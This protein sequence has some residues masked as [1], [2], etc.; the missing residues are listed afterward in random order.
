MDKIGR[1]F[2]LPYVDWRH[3]ILLDDSFVREMHAVMSEPRSDA[4]FYGHVA[5]YLQLSNISSEF[6]EKY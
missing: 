2:Y 6:A 1:A 4:N 5:Y 3:G